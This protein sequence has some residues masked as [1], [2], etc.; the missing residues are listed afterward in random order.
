MGWSQA[1]SCPSCPQGLLSRARPLGGSL[2]TQ[3]LP[4]GEGPGGWACPWAHCP[5]G[6]GRQSRFPSPAPVPAQSW[7]ADHHCITSLLAQLWPALVSTALFHRP[8]G[9]QQILGTLVQTTKFLLELYPTISPTPHQAPIPAQS[10]CR[11]KETVFF[12]I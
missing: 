4:A 2:G 10:L 6:P 9:H 5:A 1:F 8:L 3:R 11:W 7:A 12:L